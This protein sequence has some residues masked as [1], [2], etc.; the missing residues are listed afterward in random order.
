MNEKLFQSIQFGR[1][2]L[3]EKLAQGGMAEIFKA[4]SRGAHGFE[5]KLVIKRILPER[6]DKGEFVDM[7]I[8]EAKTMMRLEH[9]KVVQ[10]LDFGEVDGRYFIAMEYVRGVDCG[11]LLRTCALNRCRPTPVIAVHIIADVLDALHY[12]HNLTD[13]NGRP[14][15]IVHRDVSPSNV[16][17]SEHGEVKLSDFGIATIG[18]EGGRKETGI[19]RGKYGYLAPEVVTGGPVD[20]RA[21]IFSA[22]IVLAELLMVQ[23]LF[24]SKN[25]VDI[26]LQVRDAKLDRLDRYGKH[27]PPDLR[28][29]LEYALARNP[30]L[31]YQ[32]AA[33]F[34]NALHHY[35]FRNQRLLR[36][37]SVR[38]FVRQLNAGPPQTVAA[39]ATTPAMSKPDGRGAFEPAEAQDGAAAA[40]QSG[41][42]AELRATLNERPAANGAAKHG[43]GRRLWQR[44]KKGPPPSPEPVPVGRSRAKAM[45]RLSAE[46]ALMCNTPV[47]EER[48]GER[49][50]QFLSPPSLAIPK[51]LAESEPGAKPSS[52]QDVAAKRISTS[53]LPAVEEPDLKGD[54]AEQSLFSVLFPLAVDAQTGLLV[55]QREQTIKEIYLLDGDPHYV[56]SN[57]S[58]ELFGQ[59]LLRSGVLTEEELQRAL[60]V[61]DQHEGRLGET[62]VALEV[63]RPMQML[64]LLTR[65]VRFKMLNA[66]K[67]RTGSFFYYAGRTCNAEAAPLGLDAFELLET[68]VRQFS[69]DELAAR[70]SPVIMRRPRAV[71]PPPVSPAVF[72][73]DDY[74]RKVYERLDGTRTI[75]DLL[76]PD[77]AFPDTGALGRMLYL[78]LESG[79]ATLEENE[80]G[81]KR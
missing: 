73:V 30:G 80:D 41:P 14:L 29:I 25:Y 65:Q 56:S 43:G 22:G 68:G 58:E 20:H 42:D 32:T 51:H 5:K 50:E 9:P 74:P 8:A 81:E 35:L 46:E 23:R 69:D 11:Q 24:Y 79:L 45:A 59:Y 7:F 70:L 47:E 28:E 66:F 55:L 53:D 78:L 67:W 34:R 17:I 10:V 60:A 71:K 2:V 19:V 52:A 63:L 12:A 15:K 37:T 40:H 76:T 49:I 44:L 1:Y 21:D 31:R 54:L 48:S 16:F 61:M 4:K 72:R 64:R 38:R 26:L 36:S 75:A 62:L 3:V 6:A 18:T 57:L 33:A 77:E 39:C 27:I 13:E